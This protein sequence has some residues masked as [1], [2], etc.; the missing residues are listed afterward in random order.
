[1]YNITRGGC[2]LKPGFGWKTEKNE[3]ADERL[4]VAY[5]TSYTAWRY[6]RW[7]RIISL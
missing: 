6:M 3:K 2:F 7:F 4:W 5:Y 1:M